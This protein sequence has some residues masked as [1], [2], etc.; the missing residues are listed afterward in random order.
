M[1]FASVQTVNTSAGIRGS[2]DGMTASTRGYATGQSTP[3]EFSG[4][5]AAA[6]A[7]AD[8]DEQEGK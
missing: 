6:S 2:Y 8:E 7:A 4:L 5:V 1:G 3:Q